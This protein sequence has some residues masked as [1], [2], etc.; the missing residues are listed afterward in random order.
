ML[1][2]KVLYRVSVV[3]PPYLPMS[4][5]SPISTLTSQASDP[6]MITTFALVQGACTY[7]TV[8]SH[9]QRHAARQTR[10]PWTRRINDDSERDIARCAMIDGLLTIANQLLMASTADWYSRHWQTV[11]FAVAAP[12]YCWRGVMA[13]VRRHVKSKLLSPL[14]WR[15]RAYEDRDRGCKSV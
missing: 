6:T 15:R 11:E 3:F 2:S 13:T 10:R 12:Q 14:G 5:Q 9:S 1:W 8:P 7:T 4:L